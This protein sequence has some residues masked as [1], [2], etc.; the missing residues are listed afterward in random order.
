M[1]DNLFVPSG[2]NEV[3]SFV[4]AVVH[5][6][7]ND[8]VQ[9]LFFGEKAPSDI[10]YK[11]LQSAS[12]AELDRVLCVKVSGTYVVLGAVGTPSSAFHHG[13]KISFFGQPPIERVTTVSSVATNATLAKLITQFNNLI[14]A[15]DYRG[16]GL[17]A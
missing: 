1:S 5:A 9:L 14:M 3:S 15:L 12:I 6:V 4:M 7:H 8:G 2:T 16:Y 17:I 10:H 11:S 13:D